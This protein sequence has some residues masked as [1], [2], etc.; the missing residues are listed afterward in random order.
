MPLAHK[1]RPHHMHINVTNN[2]NNPHSPALPYE[3]A[4]TF[5]ISAIALPGFN[6]L[7]HVREQLRMVWQR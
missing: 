3:N 4:M 5:L 2:N 7:G 1:A 6:P